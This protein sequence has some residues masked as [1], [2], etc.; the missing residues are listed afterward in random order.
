MK[1]SVVISGKGGTGKTSVA[2]ALANLAHISTS[3]KCITVD[4]DVDAADLHLIMAPTIQKRVP[5][6]SGHKAVIRSDECVSCG[7][8]VTYCR[9]NA[10]KSDKIDHL[11]CEGCGVC[12]RFCPA[13]AID[14][15]EQKCGE[16]YVSDTRF[17]SLVHAKLDIASENS[18]R[19]VTLL[20]KEARKI[21]QEIN[22]KFII[23]DGSPGIGCP[24]IASLTASDMALIVTEPTVSGEH[25][26]KRIAELT[27]KLSI[28]AAVCVNKW[29]INPEKTADIKR[30]AENNGISFVGQIPFDKA[31]ISAQRDGKCIS[32]Y[33][34][35]GYDDLFKY[36]IGS[37]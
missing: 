29:D 30:Y 13:K 11:S 25:D 7:A 12:V 9:F 4:C 27:K 33:Q 5:F 15:P 26:F 31:F 20:R 3:G 35:N 22:A 17:G 10:V 8:C 32:E 21:A 34:N 28:P 37:P 14:F 18:G 23:V 2:A 36:I 19:L 1:E 16:W 24:V 6:I